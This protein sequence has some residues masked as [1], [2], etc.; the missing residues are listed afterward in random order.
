MMG[1]K[2]PRVAVVGAT[3]AVGTTMV[4]IQGFTTGY[5][6]MILVKNRLCTGL[7]TL[8]G[9]MPRDTHIPPGL[10]ETHRIRVIDRE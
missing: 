7:T 6:F 1:I 8:I 2:N 9:Y 4:T 3:G 5:T 10:E